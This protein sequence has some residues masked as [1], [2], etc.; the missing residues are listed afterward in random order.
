MDEIIIIRIYNDKIEIDGDG[1]I[2]KI[3]MKLKTTIDILNTI[4]GYNYRLIN[5]FIDR[6]NKEVYIFQK[7]KILNKCIFKEKK[8]PLYDYI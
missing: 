4:S 2:I 8:K 1:Q 7:D 3:L 6:N 5:V